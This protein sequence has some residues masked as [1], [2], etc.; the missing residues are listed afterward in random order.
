[1]DEPKINLSFTLSASQA[2]RVLAFV[3]NLDSLQ[4]A[5]IAT[6]AGRR[7]EKIPAENNALL[8]FEPVR[9]GKERSELKY[10]LDRRF[11]EL[12]RFI[13]QKGGRFYNDELAAELGV[14]DPET[15]SFLGHLT[16]KLRKTGI[17]ADGFRGENWYSKIRSSGR[18]MI[19]VRDDVLASFTKALDD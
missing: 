17:R 14:D 6:E 4:P 13:V 12:I 9:L 7:G 8:R 2:E 1:M 10:L 16:R 11:R 3:K 19:T 5:G 15:S 18:T